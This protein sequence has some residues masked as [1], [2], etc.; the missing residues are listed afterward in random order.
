MLEAGEISRGQL[1]AMR[2]ELSASALTRLGA[3]VRVRESLGKLEDALQSPL[4]L[5]VTAWQVDPRTAPAVT[6]EVQP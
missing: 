2:L 3:I 4:G 1:I 5:P 6:S